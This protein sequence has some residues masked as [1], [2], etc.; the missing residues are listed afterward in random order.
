M[1]EIYLIRHTQAEGN[2][3][4]VIQGHW[5]GDVTPFGLLEL[6]ALAEKFKNIRL[7]AV[8]S[9]DLYRAVRT[10]HAVTEYSGLEVRTD[11]RLRELNVGS[12]EGLFFCNLMREEP[13][14]VEQFLTSP[15]RWKTE[16]SET[17]DEVADRAAE[18]MNE[19]AER[20]DG[21]KIA[22]VS[23][24]VTIRCLLTRLLGLPEEGEGSAPI[25]KNTAVCKLNYEHGVWTEEVFN[26]VS[27]LAGLKVADWVQRD[28]LRH[29]E[30]DPASDPGYYK[31]CYRDA[32]HLAH[33]GNMKAF[34]ADVYFRSALEHYRACSGSVLKLLS[35]DDPAGLVDLDV[36]RGRHAGYG[37][38]SFLYLKPE[39]RGKGY[40][41]Q[42]LARAIM[43]Y[44]QL[45]R[46]SVRLT[47]AASNTAAVRFY[48]KYGF[49]ILSSEP[50][51]EGPLYLM[52][53]SLGRIS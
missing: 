11:P 32:W 22:V 28:G 7:D 25:V 13:E 43:L 26:D 3:Y 47:V 14:L 51:A 21:K 19:L 18:A 24:G 53:K 8:W 6:K 5:D 23:H 12:W 44:K 16:G 33:G 31:E 46:R 10:A 45:D 34:H 40:G 15:W 1:T 39:F 27:H 36:E 49:R 2:L 41:I 20:Y 38:I 42:A 50:G 35:G 37:W 9:S 4:R 48:E 30:L 17:L 29:E 52:E